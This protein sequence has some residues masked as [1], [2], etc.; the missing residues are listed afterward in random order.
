MK[1]F[2]KSF[3]PLLTLIFFG[4][5][6]FEN[7]LRAA[8]AFVNDTGSE[9]L[10]SAD[11]NNDGVSDVLVVDKLTGNLRVGLLDGSGNVSWSAPLV[12]SVENATAIAI[13]NFLSPGQNAVAIT[14][15]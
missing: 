3:R 15:R 11:F 13:G 12:S 8:R 10:T 5:L 9:L 2:F 7:K 14:D 1:I 6:V 4:G